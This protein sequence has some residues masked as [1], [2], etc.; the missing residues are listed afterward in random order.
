M[1]KPTKLEVFMNKLFSLLISLAI[2][3]FA[4]SSIAQDD[5]VKMI[6]SENY[7]SCIY[8]SSRPAT[9]YD[10]RTFLIQVKNVAYEKHVY[11]HHK[12]NDSLWIDLPAHYDRQCCNSN[13]ELWSLDTSVLYL[14]NL[15]NQFVIKYDVLGQT[16]W[17]NN[18]GANYTVLSN[19]NYGRGPMLGNDIN[20]L[21]RKAYISSIDHKLHADIDL[22]NIAYTKNVVLTY[23][24]DNWQHS[25]SLNAN[26]QS[27]TLIGDCSYIYW[28]NAYNVERWSVVSPT[29][30]T[31]PVQ[32][33]I[34]Y[35]VN[36]QTFY[37]NN[38]LCNYVVY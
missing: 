7:D 28:P 27:S 33:Y 25:T 1:H 18:N 26:Y 15:G 23:T 11:V 22:R 35:T 38:Y 32:L 5:M 4:S 34:S 31:G 9:C 37:D 14:N 16:Y 24:T 17:D 12:I 13:Y 29:T 10:K 2:L 3:I 36:G 19:N 30:I 8:C 20:V 6:R 21:L